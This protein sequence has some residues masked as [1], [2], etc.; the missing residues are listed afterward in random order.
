MSMS[1]EQDRTQNNARLRVGPAKE[2]GASERKR[3]CEQGIFALKLS[4]KYEN[5]TGRVPCK[6]EESTKILYSRG[7][8]TSNNHILKD[9]A[10]GSIGSTV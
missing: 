8:R 6:C 1:Q 10:M 5:S 9:R 2:G 3:V 4:S 7:L